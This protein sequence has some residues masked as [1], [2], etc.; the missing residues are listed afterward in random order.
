MGLLG[1]IFGPSKPKEVELSFEEVPGFVEKNLNGKHPELEAAIASVFSEIKHLLREVGTLLKELEAQPL[2]CENIKLKKIVK[3][4]RGQAVSRIGSLIERLQP[5]AT[6]DIILVKQYCG[7]AKKLLHSEITHG[8][9][10]IAYTGIYLKEAMKNLGKSLSELSKAFSSLEKKI[11]EFSQLFLEQ[12]LKQQLSLIDEKKE[13]VFSI[14]AELEKAEKSLEAGR[15]NSKKLLLELNGFKE[16]SEFKKLD[17]LHEE[18]ASLLREKQ[19]A[20]TELVSLISSIDRPLKR[21]SRSVASG[22]YVLPRA[23]VPILN[24]LEQ[25]PLQ[26]FKLDPEGELVKTLLIELRKAIESGAVE[27]KDKEREKKLDAIKEHL[28]FNFFS[29]VFRKFKEIDLK[30]QEVEK[31]TRNNSVS[32]DLSSLER[33]VEGGKGLVEKAEKSIASLKA[34]VERENIEIDEAVQAVESLLNKM[35][36]GKI[37]LKK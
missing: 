30:L 13:A 6:T 36:L 27:L 17:S 9:K 16:S 28:A 12:D 4:S 11:E 25:N 31:A 1:K 29:R 26:L 34:N 2:D 20:K 35:N 33:D 18:K 22:R 23:L 8:G 15:T 19:E 32:S 37:S 24:Q 5:P 14:E 10:S 3:T 21:L 7:E